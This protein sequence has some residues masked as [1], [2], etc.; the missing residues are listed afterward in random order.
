VTGAS[1]GI[2]RAIAVE[3]AATHRVIG[4]Y[5]NRADAAENLRAET[6]CEIFRCDIAKREDREALLRFARESFDRLDL[7]VNN[8]G[9]APRERRDLL[10]TTEESFATNLK[11]PHF[12]TQQAAQWMAESG[13]GRIVFVTSISAYA[14]SVNRGEYCISKAGLGMSVALYA[15]RLADVG[16]KVF[17]IRPGIIRTD[18]IAKVE[19]QYEERIAA[20]LLPQRRMG[21]P[22]D[23]AR[24]V[25]AIANG[26]LDYS[27]GQVLN[28]DGGFHLRTL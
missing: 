9:M 19:Q 7:L 26:L 23:V 28:V 24:A 14:A 10:E 16:I 1:R 4:T 11:G 18:M 3:L 25:G 27:T 12:L 17:E 15:A 6:G 8:A 5:R 13:Q 2:G 22:S 21:E 20:G